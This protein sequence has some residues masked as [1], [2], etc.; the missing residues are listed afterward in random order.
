MKPIHGRLA[1][2]MTASMAGLT[3]VLLGT[4]G[5]GGT[6]DP[7]SLWDTFTT[8]GSDVPPVDMRDA[9]GDTI[10]DSD[11]GRAAS[12]DTDGDTVLDYMDD[13]SDGDGIPDAYESGDLDVATAPDDSDGDGSADFRDDDSDNN[14]IFDIAEGMADTDGDGTMDFADLDNDGDGILDTVELLGNPASPVDSDGDTT[15]DYRDMDSDNDYIS[16]AHERTTDTDLD[17]IPDYLD[18]DT[19]ADTIPDSTE[20]GDSDIT[21]PPRDSDGDYVPDFRDPDSDNDGLPDMWEFANGANPYEADTDGDG[22]SD[23]IEVGASTD[24]TNPDDNPHVRGN[25]VFIVEYNDPADPPSVPIDPDPLVDHLVFSTDLQMADVF[26]TLDSSG[27]MGGEI[28]N[29]RTTL[30]T[31]V[32]P[33]VRLE[34]PDVW[35]GVGRFEDCPSTSCANSMA[36]LQAITDN[37]TMVENALAT[38]TNTCGG[39]EP[40]TQDLYAIATGDVAPFASWP[41]VH[42]TSWT[43][44]AP[45]AIGWPCFRP[46]AI[47]IVV[48]FGDESFSEGISSCSPSRNHAQAIAAL[49]TISARYIGVNSGSSRSDMLQIANG[50]GSVDTTG[51]ALVFD[52]SSDGSGLGTQVVTA[53]SILANQ[54]PIEVTTDLRDDPSD[55]VDT[56]EA[57]IDHVEPSTVG[58]WADPADSTRVCVSG[59]A[60]G[61]LYDPITGIPDSFTAVLPGT[62]VCFDIFA[63]QNWTVPA[64]TSPQTFLCDIDVVGDGITILDTRQ[65]YFLVPPVI[66]VDIPG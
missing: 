24:F 48:Q 18:L 65:V 14:G 50:T 45:G 20:A 30:R 29:L 33:G 46:G 47:P 66:E 13:D 56:V 21:T 6:R 59:L 25:F 17:V 60:V 15:P 8:D 37:I 52:I 40:Y 23:L 27:S 7:S 11:E 41:G 22:T 26:F 36:M 51:T 63:K 3:M 1:F 53:I 42:P 31:T 2:T 39:W 49:G 57:F 34:I 64:T 4:G 9:D 62:I 44:V 32:V 58:G 38:M 61:D 55:S 35:F 43:C 5:C 12:A 16:D 10:S 54:V 28:A 19:D